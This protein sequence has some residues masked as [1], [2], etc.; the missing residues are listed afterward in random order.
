[1]PDPERI[2][3]VF[4]PIKTATIRTP[5]GARRRARLFFP[6][7][8]WREDLMGQRRKWWIGLLPLLALWLGVNMVAIAP[9]EGDLA[10]RAN[11]ALERVTGD[12]GF[13]VAAGR[14]VS[15]NGRIFD[16]STRSAALAAV[17]ALPGVRKVTDGLSPPP[18]ANPWLWR[19]VSGEWRP[20]DFGR[21]AVSPRTHSHRR[22]GAK[23]AAAS[24]GRRPVELFHRRAGRFRRQGRRRL[25]DSGA[26]ERRRSAIARRQPE[27]FRARRRRPPITRPRSRSRDARP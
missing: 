20:D 6:A 27:R 22:G 5:A 3:K 24:A 14:D 19:A 13:S 17:A 8:S 25:A 10:R 9:V 16:E 7:P 12:P 4:A 21:D 1:M 15:L 11:A 26:F 23:D 2:G 18:P